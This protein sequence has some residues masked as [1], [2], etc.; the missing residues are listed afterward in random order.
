MLATQIL[1][2]GTTEQACLD[3]RNSLDG[4]CQTLPIADQ[5]C[6]LSTEIRDQ[7]GTILRYEANIGPVVEAILLCEVGD[8]TDSTANADSPVGAAPAPSPRPQAEAEASRLGT[9]FTSE[10]TDASTQ[11]STSPRPPRLAASSP[12]VS[13]ARSPRYGPTNP[14]TLP[15]RRLYPQCA[16]RP[17]TVTTNPTPD[18]LTI[19]LTRER[20]T[21]PH[22]NQRLIS[23]QS[24]FT[25][26][27]VWRLRS[28]ATTV[29]V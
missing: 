19:H 29:M 2:D 8:H 28:S 16:V 25:M 7:H 12:P 9:G 17:T 23:L 6:K 21:V 14:Q 10:A 3:I 20:P 18:C 4:D 5:I 15:R 11:C 1:A 13:P 26:V 22:M 27:T 24:D